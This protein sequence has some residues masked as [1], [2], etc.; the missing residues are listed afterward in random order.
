MISPNVLNVTAPVTYTD[1]ITRVAYQIHLPLASS[2]FGYNDEIRI[3]IPEQD[4]YYTY[5]G[6]S[7]LLIEGKLKKDGKATSTVFVD[8]G[9]AFLFDEIRY[10][11]NNVPIDKTRHLGYATLIKG[12][13]SFNN[14]QRHLLTNAGFHNDFNEYVVHTD[15]TFV[16][17]VPLSMWLGFAEDVKT[18]IVGLRQDLILTRSRNDNDVLCV[19]TTE[20]S[21]EASVD[22]QKI[23]WV[24]PYI[25]VSDAARI[26]LLRIVNNNQQLSLPFRSWELFENPNLAESTRNNW[27]ITSSTQLE[28]PRFVIVG[29]QTDR[30]NDIRRNSSHFDHIK[31]KDIKLFLNSEYYPYCGLD[32]DFDKKRVAFLYQMY[33]NFWLAYYAA[34]IRDTLVNRSDF[35]YSYP[36]VVFD[37]SFQNE[38]LKHA[39]VDIR[40]EIETAD[41]VPPN[42]RCL[43]LILHDQV[44]QYSAHSRIV[45]KL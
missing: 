35:L 17:C 8:N 10:E 24:M 30:K 6:G 14:T 29:F 37:C 18:V 4:A 43:C 36:L 3:P 2:Q 13:V 16:A 1:A 33:S 41:S 25:S 7:Y 45:K 20:T 44:V 21:P 40:L 5:P 11:L 42:T 27:T 22:I 15:G 26:D 23:S 32:L 19:T 34:S 28:K 9:I 31:L 39:S 38:Q 12:L